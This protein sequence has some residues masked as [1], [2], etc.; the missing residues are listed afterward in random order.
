M[1]ETLKLGQHKL[2]VPAICASVI[3]GS[4]DAMAAGVSKA[5]EKGVDIVELRL[6][7][8]RKLVGWEKLL[9]VDV[10]LIL[11]NRAE[12]EGGYFKGGE[13]ARVDHLLKGVAGGVACVDIEL[14]TPKPLLDEVI[15]TA[16]AHGT[17]L[18]ITHH[19]FKATPPI[20]TLMN[21]AERMT[22]AGCDIA[23]IV[24]FAKAPRDAL[25]ILDFLTQVPDSVAV[26]VIA[27][28]MG[29]AGRLSRI[30]APLF[31]SPI[32]YAAANEATAPGQ[33]DVET[34]GRLLRE[35]GLRG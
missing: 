8:L 10:P 22:V 15:K 1:M 26:P 19:D 31:G 35:F 6:D 9:K 30:A 4:V 32:V 3:G 25:T 2:R 29:D 16:K 28:A 13:R 34:T 12:R 5:I 24:T 7:G 11:T 21:I 20:A 18:L 14:S 17:S 23:K 33:F 27:F